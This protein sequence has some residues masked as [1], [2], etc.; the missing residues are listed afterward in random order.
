MKTFFILFLTA[1]AFASTG[2]KKERSLEM[3]A[4]PDNPETI[5]LKD[6]R[7]ESI[8]NIPVT[9][10]DKA[11]YPVIDMHS[12]AYAGSEEDIDRWV[13]TMD[14]KGIEKT[15][16]LSKE[17]GHRFDSVYEAYS[18]YP[19]RF[20]VWCGFDYSTYKDPDFP[21]AAVAELERCFHKGATGV[22]ELGDKGK[23]LYYSKP[24]AWGMH[25]DDT[26]MDALWEKCGELGL[27]VSIHV[28]DPKWMYENMDSTNDGLMNAYAWRLDNQPDIVGHQEMVDI[29]ERTVKK[30][31]NTTFIACHLAN[32]SYD[33]NIIGNLLDTY[34]N[35]YIDISARFAEICATPRN[36]A[37]FLEKYQ[38]R[39]VYGTDMGTSPDMYEITFRLLETADEHIYNEN[40][41]YHWPLHGL[42]LGNPVLEKIYRM[43]AMNLTK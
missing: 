32:C 35:L 16:I 19:D 11:M 1:L 10:V 23:G 14:A 31:P 20:E 24:P 22:G 9:K 3:T 5:L 21:A 17:H 29:L 26:R 25:A 39:I 18:K 37:K 38:D 40:F 43:N 2:C 13:K 41:S 30:H 8:Y 36:T 15:I 42:N 33:L 7:P 12:H 28:A 6:F 34:P 4:A 27:P